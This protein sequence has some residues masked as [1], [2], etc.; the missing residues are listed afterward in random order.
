MT[1][2]LKLAWCSHAAAK[3]A[4]E[5]W[6][7]SK[8]MPAGKLVKIGVWEGGKFIG[9]VIFG[10]GA[11]NHIGSRYNLDQTNICELVRV[12]LTAHAAPV[13]RIVS[14]ALKLLRGQ[15][16]GLRLIVSYADPMQGHHGGVYQAGNWIY[17]GK[18]NAQRELVVGGKK[19]HKRTASKKFGTARPEII[20]KKTGLKTEY[21]VLQWK[22]TYLMPLDAIMRDKVKLLSKRYPKREKKDA[23]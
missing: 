18:S 22:H 7:Y 12:A 16:P 5:H 17:S 6:H 9:A 20:T 13:T 23:P 15:S 11:N 2:E 4:C 8:V 14:L 21:D 19:M 3:Y 1:G 10:R